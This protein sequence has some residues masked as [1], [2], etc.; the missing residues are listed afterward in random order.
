[1]NPNTHSIKVLKTNIYSKID[2]F[3]L[4]DT[5]KAIKSVPAVLALPLK[6]IAIAKP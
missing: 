1:M 2:L 5:Y 3:I 6:A 4:F